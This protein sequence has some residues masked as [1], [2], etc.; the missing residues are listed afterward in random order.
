[1]AEED[2]EEKDVGAQDQ[3]RVEHGLGDRVG[4]PARALTQDATG[5]PMEDEK[6]PNTV[7]GELPFTRQ[8]DE[9]ELSI[10]ASRPSSGPS[11]T[12][13]RNPWSSRKT[14]RP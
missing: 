10:L 8:L 11:R 2:T 6:L 3:G 13:E 1:M 9:E 7:L 12:M 14:V 5:G 4:F